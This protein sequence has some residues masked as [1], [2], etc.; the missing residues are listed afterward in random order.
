MEILP[1]FSTH[2][3]N[4]RFTWITFLVTEGGHHEILESDNLTYSVVS[5][6][7][8]FVLGSGL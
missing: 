7:K 1:R 8:H 4:P 2:C 6:H 5:G 3:E